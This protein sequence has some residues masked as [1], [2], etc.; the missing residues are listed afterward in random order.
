MY[1]VNFARKAMLTALFKT[2]DV[3]CAPTSLVPGVLLDACRNTASLGSIRFQRMRSTGILRLTVPALSFSETSP[4]YSLSPY[5]ASRHPPTCLHFPIIARF[6]VPVSFPAA[7]Q[8]LRALPASEKLIPL[9]IRHALE[10]P[11]DPI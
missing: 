10:E 3:F 7:F 2:A 11:S 1:V 5:S 9:T 4:L 8:Q 6:G